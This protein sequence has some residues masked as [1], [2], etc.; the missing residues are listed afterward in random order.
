[1]IC[2]FIYNQLH[3]NTVVPDATECPPFEGPIAV[4]HSAVATYYAPSDHS[5]TN[6]MHRQ[7]IWSSRSWHGGAPR[8]D[9]VFLE[10]GDGQG[11]CGLD[12]AKV[13]MFFSFS[14]SGVVYPCALVEQFALVDAM[15]GPCRDTGMWI[16]QPEF[17]RTGGRR[18]T[19]VHVDQIVRGAH[20]IGVYGD[21]FLPRNFKHTDSL[22]A[23]QAYYV[24]KYADHHMNEIV[25]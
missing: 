23:F 9:C 19:V 13:I 25:F 6:G 7:Q 3:P 14:S 11:M 8:C 18:T 2:Q 21:E 16:V 22:S 20:L 1:M 12:V 17:D 15:N 10:N 24:N 5:G 4:Y